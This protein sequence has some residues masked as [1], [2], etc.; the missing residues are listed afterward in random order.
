MPSENFIHIKLDYTE[1]LK[2]KKSILSS[3][4]NSMN[5]SKAIA[6]YSDLR[7]RELALKSRAYWKIKETKTQIKKL[8]NFLP[9]LKIPSLLRREKKIEKE[10][11]YV[12]KKKESSYDE[13]DIESQLREIQRRLNELQV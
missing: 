8:Q 3:E 6:R 12:G 13:G 5:I 7:M 10:E 4:L 9:G 1:A 2:T 11:E